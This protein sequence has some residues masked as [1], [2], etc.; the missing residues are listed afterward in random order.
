MY[1]IL[2]LE[3]NRGSSFAIRIY[4]F[5]FRRKHVSLHVWYLLVR[6]KWSRMSIMTVV[7]IYFCFFFYFLL[8]LVVLTFAGN[9]VWRPCTQLCVWYSDTCRCNQTWH[10]RQFLLQNQY[11]NVVILLSPEF[12]RIVVRSNIFG[13]QKNSISL[14]VEFFGFRTSPALIAF[15]S[16]YSMNQHA[17][18]N[19]V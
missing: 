12:S 10:S 11:H 8:L 14:F 15:C 19:F 6:P 3:Q 18:C 2:F 9:R 13:C 17:S 4:L 5:R 1:S 7:C 16:L